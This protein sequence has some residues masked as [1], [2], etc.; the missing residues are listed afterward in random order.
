MTPVNFKFKIMGKTW[1]MR[2]LKRKSYVKK[3]GTGSVGITHLHKRRIDLRPKGMDLET[4]VHELVHAYLSEMCT[5]SSDLDASQL[6]E[7]FSELMAKRGRELL[8]LADKLYD[9]T[10]RLT[11]VAKRV[12]K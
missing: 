4:I 1:T 12:R 7:I 6:E 9:Q 10:E 2:L 8:D 3:N 11:T 5:G